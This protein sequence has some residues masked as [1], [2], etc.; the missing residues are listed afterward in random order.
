MRRG[1]HEHR[2]DLVDRARIIKD[3]QIHLDV[4]A[5][6]HALGHR[7]V[8]VLAARRGDHEIIA[9]L[10]AVGDHGGKQHALSHVGRWA[11]SVRVRARPCP[12]VGP[13]TGISW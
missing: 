2:G 6:Y 8:E 3:G 4:H 11:R 9:G 13:S 12:C 1:L 7:D 5:S 10:Q